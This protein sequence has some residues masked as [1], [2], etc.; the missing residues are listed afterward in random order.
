MR[1]IALLAFFLVHS[2]L[3]GQIS[4]PD[5]YYPVSNFSTDSLV[6]SGTFDYTSPYPHSEW[7]LPDT[8]ILGQL[9][10]NDLHVDSSSHI[11]MPAR[12]TPS[13]DTFVVMFHGGGFRVGFAKHYRKLAERIVREHGY[14]AISVEYP[15][16]YTETDHPN[17]AADWFCNNPIDS[18]RMAVELAYEYARH[19]MDAISELEI[20]YKS[21][22]GGCAVID[23]SVIYIPPDDT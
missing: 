9:Q 4:T 7:Y 6:A 21:D 22:G 8:N 10:L 20:H 1:F 2:A 17:P 13:A 14:T 12:Y 23:P 11:V 15:R 19:A 5:I 18:F 3:S 16:G